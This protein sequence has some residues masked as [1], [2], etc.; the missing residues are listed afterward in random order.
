[1]SRIAERLLP[2]GACWCGCGGETAIGAFFVINHDRIAEAA[3]MR[4]EYGSIA[5]FLKAHGYG[6][7][8]K[9]P[10]EVPKRPGHR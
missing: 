5:A 1:M 3:V 2:T 6:P 9:K 4:A 10:C 7:E 8:G